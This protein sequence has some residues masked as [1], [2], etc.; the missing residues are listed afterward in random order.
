MEEG[1]KKKEEEREREK[2]YF[3]GLALVLWV[4]WLGSMLYVP[5]VPLD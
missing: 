3:P 5:E 1:E 4:A 2:L